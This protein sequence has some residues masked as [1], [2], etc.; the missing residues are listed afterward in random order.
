MRTKLKYITSYANTQISAW[1][2]TGFHRLV[3]SDDSNSHDPTLLR[4][5]IKVPHVFRF[6]CF[7]RDIENGSNVYSAV[8][9]V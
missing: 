1:V 2:T 4:D 6:H 7:N 3:N 9:C 5:V 8:L